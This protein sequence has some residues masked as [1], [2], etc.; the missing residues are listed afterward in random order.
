MKRTLSLAVA[1]LTP[2]RAGR[3]AFLL[4]RLRALRRRNFRRR[5][6]LAGRF[7]WNAAAQKRPAPARWLVVAVRW[8]AQSYRSRPVKIQ[9]RTQHE[10]AS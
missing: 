8:F 10:R 1:R 6:S 9:I 5:A 3:L 4:R 7:N 2:P